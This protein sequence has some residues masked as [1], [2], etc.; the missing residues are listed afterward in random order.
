MTNAE[1]QH[2]DFLIVGAGLSGIGA[3]H[4]FQAKFPGR[5]FTILESRGAIG[6]TWDLFRYPG[7]RSDSDMYTL[8]YVFKPWK[9]EKS[10][11]DGASIRDYIVETA[12]ET[13]IDRHIRFHHK[14]TA[15]EW[16]SAD[17]RWTVHAEHDGADVTVTASFVMSCSGYYRYDEGFTPE[18]EGR[19]SFAGQV[20]HPQHW[21]EDLELAGK[22]VVVIGSGA[23]AITLAPNLA[24]KADH[25]TLLQRSPSYIMSLPSKDPI[26]QKLRKFLPSKLA[27]SAIRLKN[28][29]VAVAMYELCQRYPTF[30]KG[31]IR[32]LQEGWL[33]KGYDIDTHFTPRYDPWDQR[34]C[35]VPDNDMFRAIR[36]G[37]V[38]LVTDRIETFTE[39]GIRLESG[40]EL[41]ADVVVTATGLNLTALGDA[42]FRVDGR[43][44]EL[45]KTMA[46][47]GMMLTGVPNFAFIVGYTNASW[48]LKADLVCEYVCRLLEHM[49]SNHYAKVELQR[50][51]SVGEE[52]FLDFAAGYVLRAVDSFPRQGSVA[53]WRLRMNYFRDLPM[54]KFGKV[55]DDA[56]VFERV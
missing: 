18:F 43:D 20:V 54:L 27:Y 22:K 3:A 49:E 26:A 34:L 6:G 21:P 46:F 24:A 42:T 19:E 44:V 12:R 35:L 8:G 9:G 48:T 30:M 52:P 50:D 15:L 16:S 14:V 23:T 13:G 31:R 10:I 36:K 45:S 7:I 32:K 39:T 56:M 11:A 38:S 33:P 29:S 53:P 51:P 37:T 28:V 25:V 2:V 4:H 55:V 47:K 5:T 40:E 17:N 41:E 1:Q